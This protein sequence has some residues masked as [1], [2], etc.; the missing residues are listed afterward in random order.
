MSAGMPISSIQRNFAPG[1]YSLVFTAPDDSIFMTFSSGRSRN[2]EDDDKGEP[3]GL[4]RMVF[5]VDDVVLLEGSAT[6][7][8][9]EP[10]CRPGEL[11]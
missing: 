7:R 4:R 8:Y 11:L 3:N 5:Q 2:P 9:R 1:A 10:G 6:V